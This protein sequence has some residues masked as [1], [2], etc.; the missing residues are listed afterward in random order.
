[1]TFNPERSHENP[2][3][4]NENRELLKEMSLLLRKRDVDMLLPH[5]SSRLSQWMMW[6]TKEELDEAEKLTGKDLYFTY[7]S[8][9]ANPEVVNQIEKMMEKDED[10]REYV[11][12]LWT[13]TLTENFEVWKHTLLDEEKIRRDKARPL[14]ER[15]MELELAGIKITPE[16]LQGLR[17]TADE[18]IERIAPT[19]REAKK[20]L[21][22]IGKYPEQVEG[23]ISFMQGE[24]KLRTAT[25]Q[26]EFE[27]RAA[28]LSKQM[29]ELEF[30]KD[31]RDYLKGTISKSREE[32]FAGQVLDNDWMQ[33]MVKKFQDALKE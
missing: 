27:L 33:V 15:R 9:N 21:D 7:S 23:A 4:S 5:E 14:T 28:K 32:D 30:I 31:L 6:A 1:M 13:W 11:E 25:G 22:F 12:R 16:V 29:A 10:L 8:R 26:K 19:N 3:G 17:E 18:F 2:S 20:F 24:I